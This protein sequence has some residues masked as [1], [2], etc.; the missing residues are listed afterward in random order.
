MLEKVFDPVLLGNEFCEDLD[1]Q[2]GRQAHHRLD[3]RSDCCAIFLPPPNITG[4]LHIG[5]ALCYTLQDIIARYKRL[6]GEDVLFQPGVDHAGIVTQLIVQRQ[7]NERGITEYSREEFVQHVMDWK[8]VA[9]GKICEQ[10][11]KLGISVDYRRMR[12]TMDDEYQQAV[13]K[14]FVRLYRDGLIYRDQRLVNWDLQLHSAL[15]DLEV[16]EVEC[17]GKLYYIRYPI[18][19]GHVL[20]ATTRPETIFADMALAVN[21]NDQRFCHLIGQSA[22]VPLVNRKIIII[23]DEHADMEKG[24]GVVKITPAHDFDD[25]E[26]AKR[27]GLEMPSII[28]MYG[29]LCN[30]EYV[31]GSLLGIDRLE[32]RNR[33]VQMLEDA[34]YL[35]R[36]EDIVHKVPHGDRSDTRLEPILTTQWF[37]DVESLAQRAWDSVEKGELSFI[38][39]QWRNVFRQWMH[40]IRPWCLSRQIFWGHRIPAWYAPDGTVF[41]AHSYEEA[42]AISANHCPADQLIEESDV[43]DTWFSSALYPFVTL[44]WPE[45][46]EEFQ[47]FFSNAI[48]VTGFDIIFFWIARMVMMSIG[49]TG[50]IPFHSVY[51]HGLVRDERGQKMSKSRG[52]VIDP[53][54]LVEQYGADALRFALAY[55]CVP[56][57]DIKLDRKSIELA[58]NFMTKFWNAVR[59]VQGVIGDI[60]IEDILHKLSQSTLSQ[61]IIYKIYKAEEELCAAINRYRFDEAARC[62]YSLVWNVFC[63]SFIEMSKGCSD[64]LRSV[65][66][67]A[68]E[69]MLSMLYPFA[70]FITQKISREMQI[71]M[72][73]LNDFSVYSSV[74]SYDVRQ[75]DDMPEELLQID[76]A[77]DLVHDIRSLRKDI[78]DISSKIGIALS[79]D[80]ARFLHGINFFAMSRT[81]RK[82]A[83]EISDG[84]S[85][86]CGEKTVKLD[87]DRVAYHQKLSIELQE[88]YTEIEKLQ[89]RLSNPQFKLKAKPE[90]LQESEMRLE[91]CCTRQKLI[92]TILMED[93]V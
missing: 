9:A 82:N 54:E 77:L 61:W 3:D 73:G 14:V 8:E 34:G 48:V 75:F 44:G 81:E 45:D 64:D 40:N 49:V 42:C 53:L 89:N 78:G 59:F 32:A 1:A 22:Y 24:S 15:S 37:M 2:I 65:M 58:R 4:A 21:P 12:F 20:V 11:R 33:V 13:I 66:H 43:L 39:E 76:H 70:P 71:E 36:V 74:L 29:R 57:R 60:S 47:K 84:V 35:E 68:I 25:F 17:N 23:A 55:M 51:I 87:V 69:R 92:E 52:N 79:D 18:D 31:P 83:K 80:L 85:M 38:P 7:L 5:H 27:H 62:V 28:D 93:S 6:I 26:V 41:V 50:R 16:K 63:D 30:E 19:A 72:R 56:G 90:V 67:F 91:L 10:I 86:L 46:S 88:L